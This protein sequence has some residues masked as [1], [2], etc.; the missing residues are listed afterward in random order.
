MKTKSRIYI[1]FLI[2]I[3]FLSGCTK[4]VFEPS[5]ENFQAKSFISKIK[6]F[7][8]YATYKND[9]LPVDTLSENM[10]YVTIQSWVVK[11]KDILV[12]IT[13]PEDAEELYFGASNSSSKY[14][15]LN[16]SEDYQTI[17]S[18]YYQLDLN[19]LKSTK[20]EANGYKNY[21]VVLSSVEA[22]QVD[23]F[24]LVVSYNST[25]GYSNLASNTLDVKSI[26]P[27]QKNLKVGFQPL[28]GYT[29]SIEITSPSG[30][31]VKYS[32]DKNAGAK[33]FDNS[34]TAD[35]NLTSDSNLGFNWVNFPNPE[36][37]NY[38]LT[39]KIE[40]DLS[41]GSQVIYLYLA[42][43][44]EGK[45]EQVDLNAD[46]QQTGQ[47]AAIGTVNLGF[48][49]FSKYKYYYEVSGIVPVILQSKA[50]GDYAQNGCWAACATILMS[51]KNNQSY[52]IE[53]AMTNAN[54]GSFWL[55]E[56]LSNAGL[57]SS[58]NNKFLNDFGLSSEPNMTYSVDGFYS[59]L[60]DYGPLMIT[61]PSGPGWAHARIV[62]G[63]HGDG[64]SENTYL[65]IIDPGTGKKINEL[66]KDFIENFQNL[67]GSNI[68]QVIHY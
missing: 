56:F 53:Q 41:R 17:P 64:T 65:H 54:D 10:P 22:I 36:F 40:I 35:A 18:G 23:K 68:I 21:Q 43:I 3:M 47:N 34:Q 42:V 66:Y 14:M 44:T 11:G 55:N 4:D 1:S 24:D 38:S 48:D 33:V 31:T 59:L 63:L 50:N 29:Y 20:T 61:T 26:A 27:Y 37:G 8:T 5:F 52:T 60:L 57:A 45:I 19:N 15:E 51:W 12:S 49:Y 25:G 30:K 13:V 67:S 16:F 32:Y 9:L 39:A 46:I 6:C 28:T 58:D 7:E 2:A 62:T